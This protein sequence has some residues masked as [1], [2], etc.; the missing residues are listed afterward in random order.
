MRFYFLPVLSFVNYFFSQFNLKHHCVPCYDDDFCSMWFSASRENLDSTVSWEN[1]SGEIS[2]SKNKAYLHLLL[3]S[4]LGQ[5][6]TPYISMC[7]CLILL[8]LLLQNV[9]NKRGYLLV[10]YMIILAMETCKPL[11]VNHSPI[12]FLGFSNSAQ[13]WFIM[14]LLIND[15][16][17]SYGSP[18]FFRPQISAFPNLFSKITCLIHYFP[19]YLDF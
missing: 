14:F 11:R 17:Q 8:Y 16:N 18:V 9:P 3:Q 1:G 12:C 4:Q 6:G 5:K 15:H 7:P 2:D 13:N 10:S 19:K